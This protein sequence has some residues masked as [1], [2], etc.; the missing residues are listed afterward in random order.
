MSENWEVCLICGMSEFKNA[1]SFTKHLRKHK[2][3]TKNYYLFYIDYTAGICSC[4]KEIKFFTIKNG[5]AKLCRDCNNKYNPDRINKAKNTIRER[6]G[7]DNPSQVEEFKEKRKQTNL[8]RFGTEHAMSN[9]EVM[10]RC[11]KTWKENYPEGHPG[12]D[13]KIKSKKKKTCQERYGVNNPS[14]VEEFKEKRKKTNLEKFGYEYPMTNPEVCDKSID[15]MLQKY[16]VRS[17][18]QK[19]EFLEKARQTN[20]KNRGTE[21]PMQ[22]PEVVSKVSGP[23][24]YR[25]VEDR[26]QRFAPYTKKFFDDLFRSEIRIQ[27][28]NLDPLTSEE[29]E[30]S[31]HLHHI[32]YDKTNDS[33]ENLIFLNRESH[34]KTN[35]NRKH[36]IRVLTLINQPFK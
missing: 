8:K 10:N 11:Q 30:E 22:H 3:S 34:F 17:A 21:W 27:Q 29:L 6:Y 23:N 33:R 24:S 20:L 18:L 13:K 28:D 1:N 15:A 7:V 9:P 36:W 19:E 5:F 14:Q 4:G 2:I 31:A 16:G 26:E 12:R 32:D 25:W 35:T